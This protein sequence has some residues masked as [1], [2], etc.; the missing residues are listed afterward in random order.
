MG[1]QNLYDHSIRVPLV[2]CGPGIPEGVQSTAHCY[3][4]DIYPTLCD[5][6]GVP[7]PNTVE[8]QSLV[9]AFSDP[10]ERVRDTMYFAYKEFHRCVRDERFKLIEYVVDGQRTTQLFDIENDP[11]ELTNLAEDPAHAEHVQRLSKEMLRWRDA[12]GDPENTFG[13]VF[14]QGF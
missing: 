9:P 4:Y 10:G 3:L 5:L 12:S 1:K 13:R 8:G 14:W 2:F 6:I 7:L 11:W